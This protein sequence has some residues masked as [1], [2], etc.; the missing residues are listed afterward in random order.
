MDFLFLLK[1]KA[2]QFIGNCH[3]QKASPD[4]QVR[5]Q[6]SSTILAEMTRWIWAMTMFLALILKRESFPDTP[7]VVKG[8]KT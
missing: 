4:W 5:K 3:R 6:V 8:R 1:T 7:W 2:S